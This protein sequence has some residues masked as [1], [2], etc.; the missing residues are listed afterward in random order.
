MG[1]ALE[2]LIGFAL[3]NFTLL[4]IVVWLVVAAVTIAIRL[5]SRHSHGHPDRSVVVVD[6]LLSGYLFFVI[7]VTY[8]YNWVFHLFFGEF[9]AELIGWEDNPFQHE[10]AWASLGFAIVGVLA[11]PRSTS[12]GMKLAAVVGVSVFLL[13]AA[14][15]H[16]VQMVEAG[17]FAPNNA[18]II[19]WTDVLVPVV[20]TA[21]LIAH[22]RIHRPAPSF[23]QTSS[24]MEAS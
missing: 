6:A 3:S 2:T 22:R 11:S 16:I 9:A 21:L 5:R 7:G 15:E 19:F 8:A 4:F 24:T 20:G 10:L 17:N 23:P 12:F 1:G 13:G 14:V 18:G